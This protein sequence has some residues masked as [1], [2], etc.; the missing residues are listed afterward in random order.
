MASWAG[1]VLATN[2]MN[3]A[4]RYELDEAT[5]PR[6]DCLATPRWLDVEAKTL[7]WPRRAETIAEA[8]NYCSGIDSPLGTDSPD[9]QRRVADAWAQY[10]DVLDEKDAEGIHAEC[11]PPSLHPAP[12][13]V[14]SRLTGGPA[15]QT[16][17]QR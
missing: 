10:F 3:A 14:C 17:G 12:H 4:L 15:P 9:E 6:L 2:A 13:L 1:V 8:Y 5:T 11:A 7:V 16:S